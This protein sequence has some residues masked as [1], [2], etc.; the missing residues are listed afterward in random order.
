MDSIKKQKKVPDP[1]KQGDLDSLC[2]VYCVVNAVSRLCGPLPEAEATE[3]FESIVG[4][5]ET[6]SPMGVRIISGTAL[7]EIGGVLGKVVAYEYPIQ[8]CKGFHGF[9]NVSLD[10][11][12][13]HIQ[14]FL[15]DYGGVVL[16][17]IAGTH[18]HW[19]LIHKA[20]DRTFTLYDSSGIHRL[21]RAHCTLDKNNPDKHRHILHPNHTYFLW[22][23]NP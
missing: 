12:W 15:D 2:G 1:Y 10:F 21:N 5:L 7:N 16:T 18:D 13:D 17:A 9:R 20:T 19:T 8:R 11:F 6:R 14:D 4:F 3:L 22:V 23:D